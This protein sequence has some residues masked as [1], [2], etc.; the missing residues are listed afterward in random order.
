[1][2][3]NLNSKVFFAKSQS[4]GFMFM[5]QIVTLFFMC[6][7]LSFSLTVFYSTV[8]RMHMLEREMSAILTLRM[9]LVHGTGKSLPMCNGCS[10]SFNEL[11]REYGVRILKVRLNNAQSH[12]VY[13]AEVCVEA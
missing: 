5:E 11:V 4:D 3:F 13:D 7:V 12:V 9:A 8:R 6:V 2:K 10:M 1:M